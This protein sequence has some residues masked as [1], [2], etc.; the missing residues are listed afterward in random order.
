VLRHKAEALMGLGR[1][2]SYRHVGWAARRAA[3]PG[4]QDYSPDSRA[5]TDWV[6]QYAPIVARPFLPTEWPTAIA[7]DAFEVRVP[8]LRPNGTP[9]QR[10]ADHYAVLGVIGYERPDTDAPGKLWALR[11]VPEENADAWTE[12]FASL[13]G[14]PEV[15]VCDR[16]RSALT[17]VALN[18]PETRTYLSTW[19]LLNSCRVHVKRSRL[20][21]NTETL[22]QVLTDE[23]FTNPEAYL[24]FRLTLHEYRQQRLRDVHLRRM[25]NSL[26]GSRDAIWRTVSEPHRPLSTGAVEDVLNE[27]ERKLGDRARKFC[28]LPRLN[29]LLTLMQLQICGHADSPLTRACSART[30]SVTRAGRRRGGS[31]TAPVSGRR[32]R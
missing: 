24:A 9:V 10:G 19:H 28:N 31:A 26:N 5:G 14:R 23:T 3:L 11:A 17:S 22:W 1:G 2:Q 15:V 27:L 25:E 30:M 18:W 7:V 29:H 12:L 21:N 20:G 32:F 8:R 4:R 16:G 13:T 6:S